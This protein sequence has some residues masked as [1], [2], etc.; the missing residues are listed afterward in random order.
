MIC[1]KP[2]CR[3]SG[4]RRKGGPGLVEKGGEGAEKGL[5]QERNSD[6]IPLDNIYGYP[7]YSEGFNVCGHARPEETGS[8]LC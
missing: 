1:V 4:V 7:L 2:I 3:V 6:F 8:A 5:C